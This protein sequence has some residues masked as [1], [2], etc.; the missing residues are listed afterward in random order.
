[1][2]KYLIEVNEKLAEIMEEKAKSKKIPVE[3]MI[4]VILSRFTI[5][6]HILDSEEVKNGYE[7]CGEINLDW[8]NL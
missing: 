4:S 2:K 3:Q 8:S 5:N 7:E 6:G 1:M